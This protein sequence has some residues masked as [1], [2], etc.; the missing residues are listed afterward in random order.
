MA[1]GT[2]RRSRAAVRGMGSGS[3]GDTHIGIFPQTAV[4]RAGQGP[5]FARAPLQR[6]S[7]RRGQHRRANAVRLVVLR[8]ALTSTL[9]GG[10]TALNQ[11]CNV[12]ISLQGRRPDSMVCRLGMLLACLLAGQESFFV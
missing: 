5:R 4:Q 12:P 9:A 2:G 7:R 8:L 6:A 10:W 3:L 1:E 11:V